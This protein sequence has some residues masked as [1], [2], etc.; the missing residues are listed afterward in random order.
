MEIDDIF[1][2]LDSLNLDVICDLN[3][4]K[5][6]EVVEEENF[7]L[8]PLD[9]KIFSTHNNEVSGQREPID[10]YKCDRIKGIVP[11]GKARQKANL[12]KQAFKNKVF[13]VEESSSKILESGKVRTVHQ[14]VYQTK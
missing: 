11:I 4:T 1:G 9:Y 2:D 13:F 12:M 10:T 3:I 5:S 8:V 14:I 7:I 6:I